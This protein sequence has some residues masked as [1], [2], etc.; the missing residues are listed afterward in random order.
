MTSH[1]GK[2]Y[3]VTTCFTIF[4]AR[5]TIPNSYEDRT[6]T[7]ENR[8]YCAEIT[9]FIS[10]PLPSGT[11]SPV[12]SAGKSMACYDSDPVSSPIS[13]GKFLTKNGV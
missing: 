8:R 3:R 6:D 1:D 11:R 2:Y 13:V 10:D 9:D 7:G 12:I 4:G 5:T